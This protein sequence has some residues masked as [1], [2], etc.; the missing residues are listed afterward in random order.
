MQPDPIVEEVRAA[1]EAHARRFGFDLRAICRA[2]QEQERTSG[3]Q[4]VSFPPR[5]PEPN[6]V[7]HGFCPLPLRA[8]PN[9]SRKSAILNTYLTCAFLAPRAF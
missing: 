2:L 4:L 8:H 3:R 6:I 5:R 9:I 1:R 7:R